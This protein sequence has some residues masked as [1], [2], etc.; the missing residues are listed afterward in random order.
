MA[1]GKPIKISILANAQK[2]IAETNKLKSALGDLGSAT[3][4][5]KL[6]NGLKNVA[7]GVALGAGAAI[8][9][10]GALAVS[11]AKDLMRVERLGAQTTAVIKATGGA[12]GRSKTQVDA[13]ADR[14]EAMTGAERETVT[15]GQNMLL[16]FKNIKG[17][18][19]DAATKA[20][21]DMGVA[22]NKG[23]LQGLDLSKTSIQ[24][25][26]ALN[27]PVKGISALSKVGVSFNEQQKEQI[28]RMTEAGD[29]AG[30]QGVILK[31]L[32][33]EF[34]GA[35][36]AAGKTTEGMMAKVQN[37]F[38]NIAEEVFGFIL[39]L[40]QKL[41][42]FVTAKVLPALEKFGTWLK[43]DGAVQ[44]KA[45]GDQFKTNVLPTLKAFGEFLMGTVVPAVAA[46]GKFLIS[47]GKAVLIAVGVIATLVAGYRAYI[48]VQK[49]IVATMAVANALHL[50]SVATWVAE[51]AA[52]VATT[53][54]SKA[55]SAALLAMYAGQFIAAQARTLV[56]WVAQTAALIANRVAAAAVVAGQF[57]LRGAMI[58]ATAAQWLFNAAMT[59]NPI[60]IVIALV[61]ALVA[62]LVWFFTK[63][64]AGQAI[65]TAVWSGIQTAI[66][67]VV[68]W[69]QNTALPTI[70]AVW[71]GITAAFQAGKD[72]VGRFMNAAW[73]V[74]KKV[75][76]FTPLGLIVTN[77]GKIMAFFKSIPGKVKAFFT[78]AINFVKAAWSYSPLGLIINNW[79]RIMAFF[80]GIPGKVKAVFGNAVAWLVRAGLNILIG[81]RRGVEA[82]W[83]GVSGFL[84]GIPGRVRGFLGSAG[85]ILYNAGSSI[86]NGFL[87]GLQSAWGAVTNFVSGIANWIR[88]HKGPIAYDR[89]LLIPAG[90]AIMNSLRSGL[91]DGIS[92]L[93][94]TL[95]RVT[96]VITGTDLGSLSTEVNV[97]SGRINTNLAIER[98]GA[99]GVSGSG[100]PLSV[101][102]EF[103][104][105]GDPLI[106]TLIEMLRKRVRVN[107]G[108][109]QAVLGT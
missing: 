11:T 6:K 32:Q 1:G 3:G 87:N 100:T 95:N 70:K 99:S 21:L 76:S 62:G 61:A 13:M 43:G 36:A 5:S 14:L 7:K 65:V 69:W 85:S 16:T 8:V 72:A 57:L 27:D 55:Q 23:S 104:K 91:A 44:A 17:K 9:A 49:I 98:Q 63:T 97:A 41:L 40:L 25:G 102:V 52:I 101:T 94:R 48:A 46:F 58:A 107:G 59:A 38:G 67:A 78:Q 22:M 109:V 93:K 26:K 103:E 45:F 74:I 86:I 68:S 4:A 106:D 81:M 53:I 64:K 77:W 80:R 33:G 29:V 35:A 2:A 84:S 31:E 108:N 56:G 24:L 79:S 90:Q 83:R 51:K 92:P 96:S 54:A 71:T 19:F 30:A 12:A 66:S 88:D 47:N 50:K 28:K 20:A 73:N 89:R 15:E 42:G 39:P 37:S 34:G 60:G 82:G 10:V 75:W 105:T 18:Q